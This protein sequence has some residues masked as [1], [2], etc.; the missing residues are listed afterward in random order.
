MNTHDRRRLAF[1]IAFDGRRAPGTVDVNRAI[2][3][4]PPAHPPRRRRRG[5]AVGS[6]RGRHRD[7]RTCPSHRCSSATAPVPHRQI[8]PAAAGT[9]LAADHADGRASY[10]RYRSTVGCTTAVVGRRGQGDDHQPDNGQTMTCL[11]DLSVT[12]PDGVDILVQHRPARPD[13]RPRR[14][15]DRRPHQLV[16]VLSRARHR[17]AAH[18]ARPG[19]APRPRAELRRRSQHRA[20]H[21]PARRRRSPVTM[22]SRSAPGSA[23]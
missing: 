20:A 16:A 3:P 19:A 17:R 11:N 1:A 5:H 14:R 22:S 7:D 21:R 15:A 12:L 10:R 9:P 13:R 8:V 2:R 18:R 23:R 4:P 6:R